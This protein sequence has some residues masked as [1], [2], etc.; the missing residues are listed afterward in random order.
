MFCVSMYIYQSR[1]N[2]HKLA[3]KVQIMQIV[4]NKKLQRY[5][6]FAYIHVI[7]FHKIMIT[8]LQYLFRKVTSP[9][10]STLM[11]CSY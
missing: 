9:K 11:M 10:G 4:F 5:S 6:I 3:L 7:K 2:K 8:A 1:Y